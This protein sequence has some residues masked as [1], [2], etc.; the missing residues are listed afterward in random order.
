DGYSPSVMRR[1]LDSETSR[2]NNHVRASRIHPKHVSPVYRPVRS[3]SLFSQLFSCGPSLR[4]VLLFAEYTAARPFLFREA[5]AVCVYRQIRS[6]PSSHS[7]VHA[8]RPY[9]THHAMQQTW[10]T[11]NRL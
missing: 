5:L 10:G 1:S 3:S 4:S 6:K 2:E 7:Q 9:A 8:A 11:Y